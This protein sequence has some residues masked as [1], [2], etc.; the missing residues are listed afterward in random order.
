MDLCLDEEQ[1]AIRDA[2]R[3]FLQK[4]C[5][6][7]FVRELEKDSRGYSPEL[8]EKMASLGWMGVAFPERHGGAGSSFLELC[9]L[10]EEQGRVRLQSPFLSTVALC[11]LAIERYGSE[12]QKRDFL[13]AISAGRRILAYAA[14]DPGAGWRLRGA[15]ATP[16]GE[17]CTLDGAKLFVPYAQVAD[18][19]LVVARTAG[20][21]GSPFGGGAAGPESTAAPRAAA[22]AGKAADTRSAA[23]VAGAGASDGRG[24]Q[25]GPTLLLVD[26]KAP[27]VACRPLKTLGPEPLYEVAFRG[28]RIPPDRVLGRA[29]AGGPIVE[30][31]RQ[32][33]AAAKCAEMAGGAQRVLEMSVA[34]ASERRQ[35]GRPV[36]SFQA[37]Q[38][39]CAGMAM[40]VETSRLIAFEAAW[41]LAEGLDA[42]EEV[43]VAKAWVSDAYA[44]VCALGHQVHGAVGFT[45]EHDMQLFFRH[46]VACELAFGDGAH[47][48]ESVARRLGL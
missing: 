9:L 41:R 29:G 36:G 11:G 13:D 28:V 43:A 4:E 37:V 30:A 47:H 31:I 46:A 5:S 2:A 38:H 48:R 35:F 16:D 34:Y 42:S 18:E 10:I 6:G 44:R 12:T 27:G 40:D 8:W 3:D 45:E 39:H 7:A 14:V 32:W 26:A 21:E 15:V 24:R 23:T 19:L 22:R 1:E 25:P 20:A 33:G 17:G